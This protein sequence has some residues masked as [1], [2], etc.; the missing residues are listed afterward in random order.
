MITFGFMCPDHEFQ[1]RMVTFMYQQLQS[2]FDFEE[3]LLSL[4]SMIKVADWHKPI[5]LFSTSTIN[6]IN[7]ITSI[8]KH[9][10]IPLTI[11]RTDPVV[12]A[13]QASE[14]LERSELRDQINTQ[15]LDLANMRYEQKADLDVARF[16][17]LAC[18]NIKEPN[19][20][21]VIAK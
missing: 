21:Q 5:S 13:S 2:T 14:N 8:S 9:Y 18:M 15:L 19:N 20:N 7:L 10:G 3:D 6:P 4:K 11:L 16:E 1:A 12:T 17:N